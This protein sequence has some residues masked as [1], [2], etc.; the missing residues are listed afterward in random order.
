M[1]LDYLTLS[2]PFSAH[3][4]VSPSILYEAEITGSQKSA[5]FANKYELHVHRNQLSFAT[6]TDLAQ[7]K[8]QEVQTCS[9]KKG[10]LSVQFLL[11]YCDKIYLNFC[12]L[13]RET[14]FF[15]PLPYF[16][17]ERNWSSSICG[18]ISYWLL[19]VILSSKQ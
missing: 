17:E 2:S 11:L 7:A 9:A 13:H 8:A 12:F 15:S 1:L 19:P 3:T 14:L 16:P 18:T 4:A 5:F 6:K 10:E